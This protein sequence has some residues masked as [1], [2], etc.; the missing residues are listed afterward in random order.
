MPRE[1]F[2]AHN[3]RSFRKVSRSLLILNI[4]LCVFLITLLAGCGQPSAPNLHI[5]ATSL[6]TSPMSS[7]VSPPAISARCRKIGQETNLSMLAETHIIY[8]GSSYSQGSVMTDLWVLSLSDGSERPLL[9]NVPDLGIGFLPDGVHFL[10]V[11]SRLMISDL[12]GSPL[13]SVDASQYL[14]DFP[15]YS[16]M[17]NL[18]A[19]DPEANRNPS[20]VAGLLLYSPDQKHVAIWKNKDNSSADNTYPL[21][22]QDKQTGQ[23]VEVFRS[24]PGET[25]LGNWSPN[26]QNF[27]FTWYKNVPEYFSVVYIVNAD[28]SGLRPLTSHLDRETLERPRWSP[29]GREIA[30]PVWSNSGGMAMIIINYLTGETNR[31]K[32]SPIMKLNS[33]MDQGE[34]A[35]SPDSRWLAYISQANDHFGL[36]I[37]NVESG[38]IYCG[39]NDKN[40]SIEMMDWR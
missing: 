28:G 21:V 14:Q 36:E 17:W 26:G 10:L 22:I 12:T 6:A 9:K 2:S 18:I 24:G 27:V 19:N 13:Q 37:L 25:I 40:L 16:P 39:R 29:D 3:D 32:V 7:P 8:V 1:N 35:W 15:R 11:G 31:L 5:V 30:I 33:L 34:M 4:A 20:S 23:G 38:E